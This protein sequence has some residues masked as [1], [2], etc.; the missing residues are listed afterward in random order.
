MARADRP[1][2]PSNSEIIALNFY[3]AMAYQRFARQSL[4]RRRLNFPWR[5]ADHGTDRFI[6][7]VRDALEHAGVEARAYLS[8]KASRWGELRGSLVEALTILMRPGYP[9]LP[10]LRDVARRAEVLLRQERKS[11]AKK[12]LS[13]R[14]ADKEIRFVRSRLKAAGNTSNA[15]VVEALEICLRQKF[16][17]LPD[18]EIARVQERA[19][20]S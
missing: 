5:L 19:K 17:A 9:F 11:A 14:E 12:S 16:P 13:D 18:H 20:N 2:Q 7:R 6:W 8:N 10:T 1:G 15:S 4:W 3:P